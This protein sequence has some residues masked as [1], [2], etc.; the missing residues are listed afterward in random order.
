[1][2]ALSQKLRS[3]EG[4][5]F[6]HWCPGCQEMHVFYV[7]TPTSKGSKWSFDGNLARPT[8]TP[9]MNITVGP[10]ENGEIE[11]C[12]Y[13]LSA[14]RIQFLGDCTHAIKSQTVDLP[15]LPAD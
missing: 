10:W 12:H 2:G 4:G 14:G 15:D 13:F 3:V 5:N 1:M 11:R 9:S 6:A 7:G 8:F